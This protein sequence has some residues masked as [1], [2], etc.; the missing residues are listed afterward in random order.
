VRKKLGFDLRADKTEGGDRP[1]SADFIT[2][3]SESDFRYRQPQI[4]GLGSTIDI[5][6]V[7][8]RKKLPALD[9]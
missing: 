9:F 5:I 4:R 1:S 3:I 6:E 8:S 2:I 7:R